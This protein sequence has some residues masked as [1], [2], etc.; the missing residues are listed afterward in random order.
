MLAYL[1]KK[2]SNTL[3]AERIFDKGMNYHGNEKYTN[4]LE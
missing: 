1:R 3:M 2:D 4:A